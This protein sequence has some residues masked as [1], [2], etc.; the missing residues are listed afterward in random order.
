MVLMSII[1]STVQIVMKCLD[2]NETNALRLI[3][4]QTCYPLHYEF[5]LTF[6][7]VLSYDIFIIKLLLF[8]NINISNILQAERKLC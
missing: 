2:A 6:F 8:C 5:L 3:I 7:N 1:Y 4:L